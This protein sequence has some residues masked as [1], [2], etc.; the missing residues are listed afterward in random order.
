MPGPR[1]SAHS[2]G[3]ELTADKRV[4]RTRELLRGALRTLL[5][6]RSLDSISVALLCRVA[7]VHRTTFYGHAPSVHQFALAEFSRDIDRLTTVPVEPGVETPRHV[8]ARYD[9]SMQTVLAHIRGERPAYRALLTSDSRGAFRSAL[10]SVVRP[11]A[12]DALEVFA[13]LQVAGTPTTAHERSEA[14]A[15]IAGALVGTLDVW[16]M[17][18][19]TDE[20]AASVRIASLMPAWWPARA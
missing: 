13:T 7:G 17:S 8:A 15:F 20:V 10:E 1:V 3:P 2:W 18:D 14:A 19:E 4:V 11:H 5:A 6:T 12:N 9:A 16:A